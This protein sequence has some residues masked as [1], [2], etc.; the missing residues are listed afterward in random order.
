MKSRRIKGQKRSE[1]RHHSYLMMRTCQI[2][3][4]IPDYRNEQQEN[5]VFYS[6]L[7]QLRVRDNTTATRNAKKINKSKKMYTVEL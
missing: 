1:E 3:H 6:R 2:K 4:P 5:N 7:D